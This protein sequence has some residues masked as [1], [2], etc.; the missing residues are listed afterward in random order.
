[1]KDTGITAVTGTYMVDNPVTRGQMAAFII[2]AK[3]G[4]TF[5]YTTTPYYSDVPPTHGFFKYVQ[6]MKD[7]G[8]TTVTGNY[9]VDGLVTREQMAAFLARAF[10]GMA[11]ITPNPYQGVLQGS[12]SGTCG[13]WNVSGVFLLSIDAV[14]NVYGGYYGDDADYI[15]GFANIL[16]SFSASGVAGQYTWSGAI[17]LVNNSLVGSGTW[18]G[19]NCSGTWFG[20]SVD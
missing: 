15:S 8:I 5:S 11:A 3:Y 18:G 7:V 4:E 20:P 12:W 13:V 17:S 1:M 9:D 19:G 6:K 2:R 16:G 14:G 10:L